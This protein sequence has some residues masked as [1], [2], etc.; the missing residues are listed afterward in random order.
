MNIPCHAQCFTF[1]DLLISSKENIRNFVF[2]ENIT[3]L[4]ENLIYLNETKNCNEFYQN[5]YIFEHLTN[6]QLLK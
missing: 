6:F 5:I 3:N 2:H 4:M 1:I